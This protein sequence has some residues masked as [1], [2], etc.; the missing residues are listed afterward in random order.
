MIRFL[1]V[2]AL[3]SIATASAYSQEISIR[4][5]LTYSQLSREA[6][7][8]KVGSLSVN[9]VK[10]IDSQGTGV[11]VEAE[12]RLAD[13]AHLGAEVSHTS[14][15]EG[16]DKDFEATDLALGGHLTYDFIA[17]D[18]LTV[19][20]KAGLSAHQF[21]QEDFNSSS[22][23]NGDVGLGFALAMASNMD[24]GGEY[25]YSTTLV[26]SD[27]ESEQSGGLSLEDLAIQ[28]SDI[29]VFTSFKF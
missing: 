9:D 11:G 22:L 4:P 20:G 10:D 25:T 2:L 14:F 19:F 29:S 21:A 15:R 3:T 23:I 5:K 26:R 18:N 17:Q 27:M 6:S 13:R 24:F 8:A 28:R 12:F 16:D 7:R 1:A